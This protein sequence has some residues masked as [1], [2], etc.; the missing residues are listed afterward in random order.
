MTDNRDHAYR[1]LQCLTVASRPLRVEEL[2]EILALD[3]DGAK[4][5]IPELK[6]DWRWK[7]QQEA[8]MSTCSSLITV[9]DG[10]HH[11]VVQF[12]LFG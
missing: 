6:E 8:L 9:V 3:F 11:R 4:E 7:D 12:S 10:G 2:A 5:G 1:L